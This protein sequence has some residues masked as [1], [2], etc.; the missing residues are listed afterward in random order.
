MGGRQCR[1]WYLQIK[2]G[3]CIPGSTLALPCCSLTSTTPPPIHLQYH[4][5]CRRQRTSEAQLEALALY[6]GHSL[7]M[8]RGSYDRRTKAQKVTPAV[9]LLQ[10]LHT[11]KH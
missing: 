1:G 5:C 9:E 10:S 3:G 4:S 8:Q 11:P 7:A 6:M 2:L